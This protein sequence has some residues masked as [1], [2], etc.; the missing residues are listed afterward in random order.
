MGDSLLH[1][2]SDNECLAFLGEAE[3]IELAS[4]QKRMHSYDKRNISAKTS[5][6]V[7]RV[8]ESRRLHLPEGTSPLCYG[9]S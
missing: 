8:F 9:G 7:V 3:R 6:L 1:E 4:I 2:T 5:E